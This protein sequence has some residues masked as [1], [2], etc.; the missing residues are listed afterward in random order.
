M[1]L[2]GDQQKFQQSIEAMFQTLCPGALSL[3]LSRIDTKANHPHRSTYDADHSYFRTTR[4]SAFI[5]EAR[6][7]EFDY[8]PSSGLSM[9]TYPTLELQSVPLPNEVLRSVW[10][11]IPRLWLLVMDLGEGTH[12]VATIYRG[13]PMWKLADR[14]GIQTAQFKSSNELSE[15]L[16]KIQ[17]CEGLDIAAWERFCKEL[18]DAAVIDAAVISTKGTAIN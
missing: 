13:D 8:S 4:Q 16:A 3:H 5:R 7:G 18:W 1:G 10:K 9:E 15:A 2:P 6:C 14:E 11:Y 17:E 12:H